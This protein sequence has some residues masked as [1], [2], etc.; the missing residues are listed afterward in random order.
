MKAMPSTRRAFL[1]SAAASV[2]L[3]A[4]PQQFLVYF[5]T[6]TRKN[7]KGIYVSRL[8]AAKGA[9][10]EP[11]LAAEIANPSFVAIHP[12]RSY[13]YAVSEMGGAGQPQGAVTAFA[14]DKASGKLTRLNAVP[15]RGAGPCHLNVDK[16]GR[17]L[18]VANYGSGSVA[19]MPVKGDGS[20]SEASSFIQHQGSSVN[21]QR[22]QGPHAHSVNISRD[23]RFVVVADLGMDQVLVY[24][25]DPVE[26]RIE[27]NDPPFTKVNPG[28]GPRHF[29]FHPGGRFAYVIN[30]LQSTVT[31]FSWDA[32]RGAFGEV[33]TVSTLPADFK[34]NNTTAEVV[35]HP[36]GRFLYGS[37][38]G[39]NSLAVFA[40]DSGKGVLRLLENVP[41]QGEIPR[42]FA[43]DP[44]GKW[45]F[46]ANQNTDNVVVFAVDGKTGR[47]KPNG[48]MLRIDVPVCI[49][50]VAL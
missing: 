44:T 6:Y 22:Q 47:L 40:I 48:R 14:I 42:N 8:D 17:A 38:R 23:N 37:N 19:A 46:A 26:A 13:L 32:Q 11:Q 43:I 41:T 33:Q 50:F 31:A 10:S 9:V 24:K 27:P 21:P 15:S 3:A 36:N 45:L 25:F 16:T 5:G 29:T 20:L 18:V 35:A 39:H 30:E 49:R 28:A 34:G 12:S 2:P 1:A 4:A 7:S